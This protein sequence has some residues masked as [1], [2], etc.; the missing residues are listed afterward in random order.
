M[1]EVDSVL[2][3]SVTAHLAIKGLEEALIGP[4][5]A[6]ASSHAYKLRDNMKLLFGPSTPQF[7]IAKPGY[8]YGGRA[9]GRRLRELALGQKN[10]DFRKTSVK[11]SAIPEIAGVLTDRPHSEWVPAP[12]V[13][14]HTATTPQGSKKPW[15]TLHRI[16]RG[17]ARLG[18]LKHPFPHY[19]LDPTTPEAR[20]QA[21]MPLL[22]D[23]LIGLGGKSTT[24]TTS[25]TQE[26]AAVL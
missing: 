4:R 19:R 2:E 7:A 14:R 1:N 22:L 8:G 23:K 16:P 24:R 11:I 13:C 21:A 25:P 17:Q 15:Y 10:G 5:E 26:A 9:S 20:A 3:A 12:C 6:L 18:V